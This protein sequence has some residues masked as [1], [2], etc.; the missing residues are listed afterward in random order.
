MRRLIPMLVL[1]L[2]AGFT[3]TQSRVSAASG[4]LCTLTGKKLATCCCEQK[5]G[6]LYCPLAKKAIEK[7]CCKPDSK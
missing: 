5:Y 4:V 2:V 7:C 1:L 3:V 6:H